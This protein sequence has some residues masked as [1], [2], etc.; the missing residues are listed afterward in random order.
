MNTL[1]V[2]STTTG[3]ALNATP[4]LGGAGREG[5]AH[6]GGNSAVLAGVLLEGCPKTASGGA[7]EAADP[8]WTTLL[9]GEAGDKAVREIADLPDYVRLGAAAVDPIV[10]KGVQ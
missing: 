1:I 5:V 6:L 2:S 4:L 10:L 3:H 7:P 8:N 9:S